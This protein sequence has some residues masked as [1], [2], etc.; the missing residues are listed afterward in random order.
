MKPFNHYYNQLFPNVPETRI[1]TVSCDHV[2]NKDNVKTLLIGQ[3]KITHIDYTFF[4]FVCVYV[5]IVSYY[6]D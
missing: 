4:L 2:V 6:I 5:S 3:G 1:R